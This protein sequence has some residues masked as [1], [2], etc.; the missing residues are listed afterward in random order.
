MSSQF[1][2]KFNIRYNISQIIKC[3][4]NDSTHANQIIKLSKNDQFFVKF[5]ALLMS[6]TTYLLDEALSKLKEIGNLQIEL[7]KP[8]EVIFAFKLR[9]LARK[10]CS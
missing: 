4:W 1:Y 10:R 3:V 5:V 2:D 8:L 7:S 6:D 9:A